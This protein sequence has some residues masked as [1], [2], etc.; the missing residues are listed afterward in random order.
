[1]PP[2]GLSPSHTNDDGRQAAAGHLAPYELVDKTPL[3]LWPME[4]TARVFG[5]NSW[6][7]LIPQ[8]LV[9]YTTVRRWFGPATGIIAGRSW[10]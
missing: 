4:L 10:R 5:L 9:L 2:S 7:L 3:F 6:T 8:A 1:M